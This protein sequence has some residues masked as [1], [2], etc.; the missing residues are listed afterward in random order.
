MKLYRATIMGCIL[1]MSAVL[2][3]LQ[4]GCGVFKSYGN[5]LT[6]KL[7]DGAKMK[8]IYVPS[9]RVYVGRYEVTNREFRNFRPEHSSGSHQGLSLNGDEQPAANVSWNDARAFCG[10][11][12]QKYGNTAAGKMTFRL[13]TEKE[14]ET[15]ATYGLLSE[16]PWGDWPPPADYNYYGKENQGPGQV[17]PVYDKFI[18]SCPVKKSGENDWG[19]YGAGGNVKEWCEDVEDTRS[20]TR[21]IK[22]ASWADCVPAFLRTERRS[23]NAADYKYVNLG[24][25]VIA[26]P[27][28]LPREAA[29]QPAP[30]K[31]AE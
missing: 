5:M 10:W 14:W 29:A 3:L 20:G 15:Y 19:L 27:A 31:P 17:L 16:F 8:F 25:R 2:L 18:V 12:T 1:V 4:A 6:V 23:G 7:A 28:S 21:V 24:F 30:E 9:L 22:D 11:L 13:P 26:E